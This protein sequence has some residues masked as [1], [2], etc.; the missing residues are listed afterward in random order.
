[1]NVF[2]LHHTIGAQIVH[3]PVLCGNYIGAR[4]CKA[5]KAIDHFF[6]VHALLTSNSTDTIPVLS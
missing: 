3:V 1:M 4:I 6:L 2:S 5:D